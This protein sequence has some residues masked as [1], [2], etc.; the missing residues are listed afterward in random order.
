[1][2]LKFK[3]DYWLLAP[4]IILVLIG[5][6]TLA[7]INPILSRNQIFSFAIAIIIFFFMTQLDYK[8]LLF[9]KKP[10]YI[11]SLILLSIILVIGIESRGALRWIEILGIRIQFSE[12]IKPLL[13][14]SIAAYLSEN[15]NLSLKTFIYLILLLSPV[16]ILIYLQPDLGN[17]LIFAIVFFLSLLILGFPL[18]W[19][20]LV[21]LPVIVLSPLYWSMLH[22]YQRQRILTFVNPRQDPLGTSYNSIQALIAIGSGM[23][24]GKGLGEGTQSVLKF[25]PERHTDFIFASISEG[26][27]FIGSIL[28]VV[29]FTFLLIRIYIIFSRVD[30]LFEKSLLIFSFFFIL[31]Q[32]FIN[33]GMNIGILPVVG[34]TLPFVSYG[35]SS[36]VANFIFL[37]IVSSISTSHKNRTV[38]E[39][40]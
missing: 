13:S 31:V 36:L 4:A 22:D 24:F 8:S 19:F 32:F 7:S 6:T 39:I 37:A 15:K 18:R 38:L 33:I 12:T 17:A 2:R 25:L 20:G 28:V 26:L 34:V 10:I 5:L 23:V 14:I 3:I 9:L 27:G 30:N 21:L 29:I 16:L 11:I 40:R 35:G 1:M